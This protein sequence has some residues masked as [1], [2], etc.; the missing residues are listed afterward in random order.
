MQEPV[1]RVGQRFLMEL[2]LLTEL[3]RIGTEEQISFSDLIN[4]AIREY[5]ANR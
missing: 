3:S 5:L 2:P 1:Y 4:D